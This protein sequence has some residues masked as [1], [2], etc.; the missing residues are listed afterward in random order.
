MTNIFAC[1]SCDRT[2]KDNKECCPNCT[3]VEY[4]CAICE[5]RRKISFFKACNVCVQSET[6]VCLVCRPTPSKIV[7]CDGCLYP[8]CENHADKMEA[9]CTANNSS[10]EFHFCNA[11]EDPH[12]CFE[13]FRR[14]RA[15]DQKY[16]KVFFSSDWL[17]RTLPE[18]HLTR[19]WA[20]RQKKI[21]K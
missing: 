13:A 21:L 14:M 18:L 2:E 11:F 5:S 12:L 17:T 1:Q 19:K 8:V 3:Q 7:V 6:L 4:I 20:E 15:N 9:Y 10:L 16:E